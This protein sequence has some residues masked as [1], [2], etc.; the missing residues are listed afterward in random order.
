V[1]LRTAPDPIDRATA[2]SHVIGYIEVPGYP[3]DQSFQQHRGERNTGRSNLTRSAITTVT[4]F[5]RC[6]LPSTASVA[7]HFAGWWCGHRDVSG[8]LGTKRLG[9]KLVHVTTCGPEAVYRS[10][11]RTDATMPL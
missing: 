5:P 2:D 9:V 10:A 7:Y 1:T 11:M 3:L 4:A 6:V 8:L